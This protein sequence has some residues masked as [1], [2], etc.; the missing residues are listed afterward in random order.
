[1][2]CD[3]YGTKPLSEPMLYHCQLHPKEQI[4]LK[5][6]CKLKIFIQENGFEYVVWKMLAI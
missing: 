6:Y 4:S 5:L 3:L 2:E 1:M